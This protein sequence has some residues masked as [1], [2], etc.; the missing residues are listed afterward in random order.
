MEAATTQYG[1]NSVQQLYRTSSGGGT[2]WAGGNGDNLPYW[3]KMVRSGNDFSSFISV[4]GQSWT[5]VGSTQTIPMAQNVYIGLAVTSINNGQL[6]T[7]TFDNVSVTSSANVAPVILGVSATSGSI[8]SQVIISGQ[9]FGTLQNGSLM[10]LNDSP[11]AVNSW[12]ATSITITIPSGAS[13]GYLIVSVSPGMDSSNPVN[14]EVTPNPLPTGWLDKD[15]GAVGIIGSTT[16]ANGT[17]TVSGSG[18]D[19]WGNGDQFNFVYQPLAGDGSVIARVVTFGNGKA[20]VMF[21]ETL[22]PGATEVDTTQYY[23]NSVQQLYRSVTGGGTSWAGGNS[24]GLPYWVEIV[25]TG[26]NFTS[27]MSPDGVNWS[28]VGNTQTIMMAQNVYVGLA[29]ASLNNGQ[30]STATFDN[31]SVNSVANP[32]PVITALS[33][34]TASVGSEVLVEGNNFGTLQGGSQLLFNGNPLAVSVWTDTSITFTIPPGATSGPVMVS[35][36]PGMNDSNQLRLEITTQPLPTSWSNQDVGPVGSLMGIATFAN[37][38]Y[39]VTGGGTG[40]GGTADSMHF[41]S[42]PLVGD[43]SIVARLTTIQSYA[44]AYSQAGIMIRETLD[45]TAQ[46]A[47]VFYGW[48]SAL[49]MTDRSGAG[50]STVNQ[51][52][53]LYGY[54]PPVWLELTRAGNT[55]T[56][57]ISSDGI[58]WIQV[59]S[60]SISM[61]QAV[62]VGL[63]VSGVGYLEPATFDSVSIS[64]SASPAPLISSL[65]ATTASVGAQVEIVGNNFG[66]VQGSGLVLLNGGPVTI[67][68]WSNTSIVF[69]VPSGA[70]TGDLL[71]SVAPSMNDS[72]PVYF[73][74]TSQP[75][76]NPWVDEDIG[77]VG[78]L[79]GGA[80]YSSGTFSVTGG[81]TSIGGT[82]DSM[83]FVY[84]PLSGDGS[85]VARL[86]NLPSNPY[87]GYPQAGVMIRESLSSGA[88][89]ATAFFGYNNATWMEERPSTGATMVNLSGNGMY[90]FAPPEW[91]E[92]VRTGNTFTGYVSSDGTNWTQLAST[93]ISMA[94]A[95][96]VGL[97]V[98][99][100]A[101]LKTGTFDNVTVVQGTTPSVSSVSPVVGTY[102]TSVTITGSNFGAAQGT[103][104]VSFNGGTSSSVTSWS[105]SQIVATVPTSSPVGT[106]PVTVSV[107]SVSSPV[108]TASLFTLIS[109]VITNLEPP[110]GAIGG[111]LVINGHGFGAS[112]NGVVSIN[113]VVA[114]IQYSCLQQPWYEC[115]TD[116]Q[117][118]VIIPSNASTGMVTVTNDGIVSNAMPFTLEGQ[119]TIT[120]ISSPISGYGTVVTLNGS[121]FGDEQSDSIVAFTRAAATNIVSWSDT[122]IAVVVPFG[123]V[124]GPVSVTVA[125]VTGSGPTFSPQEIAT[126]TDS[127]GHQTT[128][129]FQI[130]GNAWNVLQV[131]GPGCAS[132]SV[133]GNVQNTYDGNGDVASS[134]DGNGNTWNYGYDNDGNVLSQSIHLGNGQVATTSYTYNNFSEVLTMTDPLGNT[135]TNS[136]DARGNLTAVTSPAPNAQTPPSVTQFHYDN[137]GEMTQII[138]P[139]GNSTTLA[140]T[141]TGMISSITDA[142]NNTTSYGYD[143]RGNRTSVIDPLNGPAHPITFGYDMMN[144]LTG[145]S[146]PDGTSVGFGYDSRGRRTSATDQNNRTT[147]YSY[148]DADHLTS[149]T[150]PANNVTQYNYDTENNLISITDANNHTTYFNYD[151]WGRVVQTTF[152]STL[153]ETYGYDAVG[154]LTS[155]TDRKNQTIQYVYDALNRLTSKIY[156]DSTSANY[157]YDLVGKIRQVSDP[158]GVYGF[159]YDNMGRLIGTTTQ[160]SFLPGLNFQSA[161]AYDA[162]SN[163][164]WLVAPDS[165]TNH[166]GYDTLNRLSALTNS[167]TGQF[168]FSYDAMSRRTQLRRPNGVT[169]NYGYDAVSHLLSVLHQSGSTTLDGASYSYDYAGNRTSKTNYLN[170]IT[171]N[172]GYDLIYQL[173]QVTQ[174]G[175]TTESY[176]YDAVGNRLNSVGVPSYSYNSSNELTSNSAG[177]YTYDANGNTLSDAQGRSFTWDFENRLTQVVNPGVGTTILRYDPF[178]R[179][180]Q[181]SGPLGTTNYLYD[182]DDDNVIEEVDASGNV[183]ARYTSGQQ[184]D[185]LLSELRSGTASY[186]E[187]DTLSSVTSLSNPAGALANTYTF[188]SFG[189]VTASTGTLTNPFQYTGR[190][191][192]SETG[193]YYYRARY[194][195]PRVGRF[196]SE[197]PLGV[198][199]HLNMYAYVRNNPV[200]FDDPLGLYQTKGFDPDQKALLDAAIAEALAKLR[201]KN[202]CSNCAGADGPKIADAIE[203]TTFVYKSNLKDCGETGPLT[204]IRVRHTVA[205][206][207]SAF[208]PG[209]CCSLASTVTHEVVH[210]MTHGENKAYGIEEKCFGCSDPRK[211]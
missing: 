1:A 138:D 141:S 188:D 2:S 85:I 117:I 133:R 143:Q 157:I 172:F 49:Y 101:Y 119:P 57:S 170:G 75:L 169:T 161:Y 185:E 28:Q 10:L 47:A 162:A 128:Y 178:G 145:I 4:D 113:G 81:G 51:N 201:D 114:P 17:F 99:G 116:N 197:D 86:T 171:S 191:N 36:A 142:Q 187:Q 167:L 63:V 64:S 72:N 60:T 110:F 11:V 104:T 67:N 31:V 174:E 44:N 108:T 77:L 120:S 165:S 164:I 150:D 95:A 37:G 139:L 137:K 70:T 76:P 21:R 68:L 193:L 111:T 56:G 149:V 62:Y 43:G 100:N 146:Y 9:N 106:G 15:I 200:N 134:A 156:P 19:I 59:G 115:W 73:E 166:Y 29:V 130:D 144:R 202:N 140:Y 209:E 45:E 26:N 79:I 94:Q 61:A 50:S 88:T 147:Y 126:L 109:P 90:G 136:Y 159:A 132:C 98:S 153:T 154:N 33:P 92:L 32:A 199:D 192:D 183:L 205:L 155:K 83:H 38:T 20:G 78:T 189:N 40:I 66:A 96:Y 122:Q 148:D 89:E 71:V 118:Q 5:P 184:T 181:K 105:D 80:T 14:F 48:N 190:D 196:I 173:T 163:R 41:A 84:Q 186:F 129:M 125:G 179:R 152:P 176:S 198:R 211:P 82:A 207:P 87:P 103:S 52:S 13:S 206:G 107:N 8:G 22:D 175:S 30:F 23:S 135:T 208:H 27:F 93:T 168:G 35:I 180:I 24:D 53:G 42:Q 177:N 121:G 182:G 158:T 204:F 112:Q 127:L 46:N 74:V 69:T 195:D 55:F 12:G 25:R 34:T 39:T 54:T 7:A 151:A 18:S 65:S 203:R 3:L 97:A 16:Y 210:S 160:Y 194:F 102:G 123:A 58:N 6:T 131:Q 91:L 124:N